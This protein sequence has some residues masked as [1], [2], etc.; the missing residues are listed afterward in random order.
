M[1]TS[2]N[3]NVQGIY[4][5]SE[6]ELRQCARP[7]VQVRADWTTY[8][9]D[10]IYN[11]WKIQNKVV[12]LDQL[13]GTSSTRMRLPRPVQMLEFERRSKGKCPNQIN[14][15][16]PSKGGKLRP[17]AT[18]PLCEH[19]ISSRQNCGQCHYP[20]CRWIASTFCK[21][22]ALLLKRVSWEQGSSE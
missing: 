11:T 9:F 13:P 20:T 17:I 15:T 8:T 5:S 2:A 4:K 12:G 16:Q 1:T 6:N 7:Q 18:L 19:W 21:I 14:W 10:H 3:Q 22:W